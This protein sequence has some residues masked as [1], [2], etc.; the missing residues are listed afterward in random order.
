MSPGD[1]AA[2]AR[3]EFQPAFKR[4]QPEL[5]R[6]AGPSRIQARGTAAASQPA[7]LAQAHVV[8]DSLRDFDL[9]LLEALAAGG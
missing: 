1:A 5:R 4:G 9:P 2:I 8:L 6:A 3:V 7:A